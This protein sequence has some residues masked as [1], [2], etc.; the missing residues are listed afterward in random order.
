MPLTN[1]IANLF[2]RTR[3]DREIEAELLAHVEMRIEDNL[4]AGMDAKEA[5][6]SALVAFG[7]PTLARERTAA[8]DAALGLRAAFPLRRFSHWRWPSV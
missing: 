2:R 6:R 4:A 5:R 3:I 8:S 1:R 7:N